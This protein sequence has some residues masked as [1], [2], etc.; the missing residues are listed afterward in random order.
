MSEQPTA[1]GAF[2][3]PGV[4]MTGSGVNVTNP[5]PDVGDPFAG[6]CTEYVVTKPVDIGQ[7]ASE[8]QKSLKLKD[9]PQLV[10]RLKDEQQPSKSTPA[11][12]WVSPKRISQDAVQRVLDRHIAINPAG[13]PA[14]D[15]TQPSP[16]AASFDSGQQELV[17]QL[18]QGKTLTTAQ[19]SD[20]LKA[21]LG[22]S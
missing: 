13:P 19:L 14:Q 21:M 4:V 3:S 7:L 5:V 15:E 22:A 2:P 1:P 6:D 10:V 9:L 17:A 12:L 11:V 16:L 8:I 18:Q 20:L